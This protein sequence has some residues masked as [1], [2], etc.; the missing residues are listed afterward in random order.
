[1][2]GPVGC[3]KTILTSAM[4][5]NLVEVCNDDPS[6]SLAYFY[7]DFNDPSRR[8]PDAM[9]RSLIS[10]LIMQRE[11][12]PAE[13]DSLFFANGDR[14]P[15]IEELL[16]IVREMMQKPQEGGFLVVDA[17]DECVDSKAAGDVLDKIDRWDIEGWWLFVTSRKNA[18]G[19]GTELFFNGAVFSIPVWRVRNDIHLY[20]QQ[21]LDSDPKLRRWQSRP[22]LKDE[23]RETIA[24][25]A[26]GM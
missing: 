7:F 25:K 6:R 23:I 20:I 18:P 15:T 26:E 19:L 1:M 13:W 11:S 5:D 17:L 14:Q 16:S 8:T 22:D 12:V 10:Q 4:I 9:L 2:R 24:N 21:R 3:G